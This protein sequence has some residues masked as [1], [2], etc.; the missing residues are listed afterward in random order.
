MNNQNQNRQNQPNKNKS[1]LLYL[2]D[3]FYIIEPNELDNNN[4][5]EIFTK[6]HL[7]YVA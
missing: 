1:E 3:F 6:I 7:I 2:A 5:A 4:R